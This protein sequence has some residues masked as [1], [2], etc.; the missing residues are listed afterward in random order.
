MKAF[1]GRFYLF[2][3][4]VLFQYKI[5]LGK[6]YIKILFHTSRTRTSVNIMTGG[7][8]YFF[9]D[10]FQYRT[11]LQL[12]KTLCIKKSSCTSFIERFFFIKIRGIM[13]RKKNYCRIDS[14]GL[15]LV[16]MVFYWTTFTSKIFLT[17]ILMPRIYSHLRQR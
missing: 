10:F 17:F 11:I 2:N 1:V 9:K 16:L 5:T 4:N 6:F 13:N 3:E 7:D 8:K 12:I 15:P 14:L